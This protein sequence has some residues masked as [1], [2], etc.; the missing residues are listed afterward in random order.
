MNRLFFALLLMPAVSLASFSNGANAQNVPFAATVANVCT[1]TLGTA[2]TMLYDT[3]ESDFN[4]GTPGTFTVLNTSPS[5]AVTI[6]PPTAFSSQPGDY[7][8]TPSFSYRYNFVGTNTISDI[9][10]ID[11]SSAIVNFPLPGLNTGTLF[12]SATTTG[13]GFTDGNYTAIYTVTCS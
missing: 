4:E 2:G 1:V 10:V 6:T 11:G 5:G 3:A 12:S 13:G 7:A 8:G 9:N